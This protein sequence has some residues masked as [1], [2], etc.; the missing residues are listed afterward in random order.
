MNIMG[1]TILSQTDE[2]NRLKLRIAILE[3]QIKKSEIDDLKLRI[4]LLEDKLKD[5]GD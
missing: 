4:K 1:N 5:K 2:I 3:E